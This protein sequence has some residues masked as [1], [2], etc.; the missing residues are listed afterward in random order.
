MYLVVNRLE[1]G[2][3]AL[4]MSPPLFHY[5]SLL[6]NRLREALR[7]PDYSTRAM[8]RMFPPGYSDP[9]K[10][11]EY[12]ELVGGD[13]LRQRHEKIDAF[14]GIVGS[15]V[16]DD[17]EG[18]VLIRGE[19]FDGFLSFVNDLRI[20]LGEELEIQ[21]EEWEQEFDPGDPRADKVLMLHLLGYIE[22]GLLEATGMVDLEIDPDD[23]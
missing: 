18:S 6:P 12:R 8:K 11:E 9:E 16:V 23:L 20:L 3:F 19:Q 4:S 13:L 2:D 1:D 7:D 10:Q 22:Q 17:N 21:Q 14:E 5:L 15:G